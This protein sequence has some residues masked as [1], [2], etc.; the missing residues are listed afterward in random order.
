[1]EN[2]DVPPSSTPQLADADPDRT[3]AVSSNGSNCDEH[4][5]PDSPTALENPHL[6]VRLVQCQHCS[7][8]LHTPIRLPCG[9]TICRSCL[10]PVHPRTGITYPVAEGRDEGFTCFWASTDNCVGEHCLKDCGVDVA[11]SNILGVF[12]EELGGF[13]TQ[14]VGQADEIDYRGRNVSWKL[15]QESGDA[16]TLQSACIT[17]RGWLCGLYLLAW[18]GRLSSHAIDVTYELSEEPAEEQACQQDDQNRYERLKDRVRSEVDCQVCYSLILDPLTTPCGHT[19]CRKCVARILDHTDLCPVCRRK[20]GT[21]AAVRS[22]PINRTIA[23]IIDYFFPDHVA[24][25]RQA[26]AED[27]SGGDHEKD[28]PLFVCTLSFPTMPTFLHIFEPRYRLMIRRVVESGSSKFGMVMYNRRGEPQG[29]LGS[30]IFMQYGT[31]LRVERYELLPDGRSLVIATGI[32]RFKILEAGELDGYLVARTERVDDISVGEE[33]RLEATETTIAGIG[34][35]PSG[36]HVAEPPLDSLSTQELLELSREFVRTQRLAGAPW[37]QPR[38]M[39]AY[40]PVPTD[41]ARFPWWF[42]S[43]LPIADEEKYPL[44][45]AVS[46]RER[47]K[48]SARWARELGSRDWPFSTLLISVFNNIFTSLTP[49]SFSISLSIGGSRASP[50]RGPAQREHHTPSL[51]EA[52]HQTYVSHKIVIGAFFAIFLAQLCVNTLQLVRGGRQRR[53]RPLMDLHLPQPL[54]PNNRGRIRG[55]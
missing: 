49:I 25:R 35:D 32:S 51:T 45:S 33:E 11:L 22:E 15:D 18:E 3:S 36:P 40:G 48:I 19:F 5:R 17:R 6:V 26:D 46:V 23:Q 2:V 50:E 34:E 28:L 20:V 27:E 53:R 14:N 44:L 12:E 39:L 7:R 31:V 38:V 1:M 43:I 41:A 10:P 37:L 30:T 8:P 4:L 54:P 47:L 16:E 55:P 42:A 52:A 24:S 13:S 29:D 21:P 9:N